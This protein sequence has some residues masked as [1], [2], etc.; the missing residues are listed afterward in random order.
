MKHLKKF[1]QFIS[2]DRPTGDIWVNRLGLYHE[3]NPCIISRKSCHDFFMSFFHKPGQIKDFSGFKKCASDTMILW[4]PGDEHY[5]G[6]KKSKWCNSWIH[7]NGPMALVLADHFYTNKIIQLS[8]TG[9]IYAILDSIYYELSSNYSSDDIIIKSYFEILFRLLIRES[10]Q[11]NQ[12]SAIP[13]EYLEI[14]CFLTE[15]YNEPIQLQDLADKFHYSEAA[16]SKYFKKYF[17]CS[18]IHYLIKLRMAQ[19]AYLLLDQNLKIKEISKKV[20][21]E[22]IYYFSKTVKKYFGAPPVE[23]RKNLLEKKAVE[24]E[25][26]IRI[27]EYTI[28]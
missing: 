1:H 23:L 7:F 3:L 10:R 19:T 26:H 12:I 24:A 13:K 2:S 5:Y 18:P 21:Y 4:K 15:H 16:I 22:N 6:N 8:N 25:C 20:G 9:P 14:K 17:L 27:D 28:S 11:R